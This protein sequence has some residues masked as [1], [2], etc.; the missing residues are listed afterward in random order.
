MTRGN[1][2]L[3]K[4]IEFMLQQIFK[5]TGVIYMC[6]IWGNSFLSK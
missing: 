6:E 3:N 4:K 2:T 5:K 1:G